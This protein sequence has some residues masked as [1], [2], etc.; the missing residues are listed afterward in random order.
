M[1]QIGCAGEDNRLKIFFKYSFMSSQS[2]LKL[3][4]DG[5]F[6]TVLKQN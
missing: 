2:V 5:K 4:R 1:Y 6:L 3:K